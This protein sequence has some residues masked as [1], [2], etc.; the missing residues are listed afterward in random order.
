MDLKAEK[1]SSSEGVKFYSFGNGAERLFENRKIDSHLIGLDF[2]VHS[3]EH[4]IRATLEGIAFSLSYGIELLRR[5]GV[6]VNTVRVGNA[7]LFLSKVFREAFVSS[8]KVK[9]Q[10]YDTNGSEGAARGAALG[11]GFYKDE[12][13]AFQK[14]KMISEINPSK[15]DFYGEEYRN[16]KNILNKLN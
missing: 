9:L 3:N 1:V 14:L 8:S 4:I 12:K 11:Y 13:E 2:N 16:W 5:F 6:D 15:E 10:L 7:N